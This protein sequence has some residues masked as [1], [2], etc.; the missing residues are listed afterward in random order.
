[1]KQMTRGAKGKFPRWLCLASIV[2]SFLA[3]GACVVPGTAS[4][5]QVKATIYS[6]TLFMPATGTGQGDSLQTAIATAMAAAIPGAIT[7]PAEITTVNAFSV[8]AASGDAEYIL[9]AADFDYIR[10]DLPN[11]AALGL[12]GVGVKDDK[13]P[14]DIFKNMTNLSTVILPRKTKAIGTSAFEGCTS[15]T[16]VNSP[17]CWIAAIEESAFKNCPSLGDPSFPLVTSIGANAF[18][19]CTGMTYFAAPSA[20]ASGSVGSGAFDGCSNLATLILGGNLP[21]AGGPLFGGSNP[22]VKVYTYTQTPPALDTAVYGTNAISAVYAPTPP[23]TVTFTP[24]SLSFASG[25]YAQKQVT[26]L[27]GGASYYFHCFWSTKNGE[28]ALPYPYG[29][30]S[31]TVERRPGGGSSAEPITFTFAEWFQIAAGVSVWFP[32]HAELPCTVAS[33]GS[34]D[35]NPTPDP[36]TPGEPSLAL[37]AH[38]LANMTVGRSASG[39]ITLEITPDAW[40]IQGNGVAIAPPQANGL[41]FKWDA[42]NGVIAVSGTPSR[43]GAMDVLVSVSVSATGQADK[44]ITDT[45]KLDVAAAGSSDPTPN[46]STPTPRSKGSGGCNAGAGMA[47]LL[48]LAGFATTL[49]KNGRR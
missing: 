38:N 19:G 13:L 1:M 14:D 30:G 28:I 32:F 47:A 27:Y 46:P 49:K 29:V 15:L 11:L 17:T 33:D 24:S 2:L 12:D 25:D 42:A 9:S 31:L 34:G 5:A 3:A 41:T 7:D 48:L 21:A 23:Q 43:G 39:T 35:G 20:G 16:S 8:I 45:I 37:A 6:T 22:N 4:A 36:S 44:T 40:Q 10:N 18:S 26:A